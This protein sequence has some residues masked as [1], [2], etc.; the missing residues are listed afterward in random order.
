MKHERRANETTLAK[1][2]SF[3]RDIRD[4]EQLR[5]N[6]PGVFFLGNKEFMHF[7]ELP[8]SIVADVFFSKGRIRVPVNTRVEQLDL[9]D[10]IWELVSRLERS[11]TKSNKS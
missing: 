10:R 4:I 8:D 6:R 2:G 7:H 9:L 11:F 1:L 5:E 3:L